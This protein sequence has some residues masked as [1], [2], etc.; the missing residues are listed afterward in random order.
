MIITTIAIMLGIGYVVTLPDGSQVVVPFPDA[1]VVD[2]A[3]DS[4][5]DAPTDAPT[6]A[7][8]IDLNQAWVSHTINPHANCKGAD[9]VEGRDVDGD[10]DLDLT[11]MCEQGGTGWF[12][13][14]TSCSAPQYTV[15]ALPGTSIIGPEDASFGDYDGDGK[16]DIVDAESG[17]KI[18][19]W[20]NTGTPSSPS[21]VTA[22]TI[23]VSS[24][25][26]YIHARI[27][28]T[29]TIVA[30]AYSTSA[31]VARFDDGTKT[32]LV[33]AGFSKEILIRDCDHDGQVDDVITFD[34]TGPHRGVGCITN[35]NGSATVQTRYDTAINTLR[36]TEKNDLLIIGT[37]TSGVSTLKTMFILT[38]TDKVFVAVSA[39]D[40]IIN[41]AH[42]L[43][44]GDGPIH[45]SNSGGALPSGLEAA[46]DYYVIRIDDDT[47]KLAT[48]RSDALANIAVAIS[49][50]GTGTQTLSDVPGATSRIGTT[51]A[52]PENFGWFQAAEL[53]D[54]DRDGIDDLVITGS[55]AGST[56]SCAAESCDL[57][58]LGASPSSVVWL[59]GAAD[60]TFTTRGE[61]SGPRGVKH[62]NP[63]LV[64]VDC[65]GDLDLVTTEEK[66]LGVVWYENPVC[67]P[68]FPCL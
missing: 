52:F 36:G 17:G 49:T 53:G 31:D 55:H 6:D 7:P 54:I 23:I 3:P 16:I 63:E 9:G 65:D 29:E 45:V 26:R 5:I 27:M 64:D 28:A 10:G 60:N 40:V 13:R 12:G 62:D 58:A 20:T 33:T 59:K 8:P 19:V 56:E 38:V 11:G 24:A 67:S 68:S 1:F 30:A 21:Y 37:G 15:T 61:I 18:R 47:L 4:A 22:P 32:I 35:A 48:S 39:T 46:T 41:G 14:K 44:T 43:V 42:G 66:Y 57:D 34:A 51:I 25:I 2:A 50:D